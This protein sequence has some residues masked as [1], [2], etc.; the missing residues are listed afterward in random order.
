M[1]AKALTVDSR[2]EIQLKMTSSPSN[3]CRCRVVPRSQTSGAEI[4]ISTV[5]LSDNTTST[6]VCIKIYDI[7]NSPK[8]I[9]PNNKYLCAPMPFS[10][11]LSAYRKGVNLYFI[12]R[13]EK[14]IWL[15]TTIRGESL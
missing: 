4:K 9:S 11:Q 3:T 7:L 10:E 13:E 1:C 12:N 2:G 5:K 6:N 14:P 8:W 15:V